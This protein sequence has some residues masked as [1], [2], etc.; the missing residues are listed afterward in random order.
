VVF[1]GD[2]EKE[3]EKGHGGGGPGG[4]KKNKLKDAAKEG[5]DND[6]E[7]AAATETGT[8]SASGDDKDGGRKAAA[9][10][11]VNTAVG[12]VPR[13]VTKAA[14]RREAAERDALRKEFLLLQTA[15]KATEIAIP[16]VFYDGTNIPG[17][18]VRVKKGDHIWV[19]LD[20]SR[21]V[22]AQLGVGADKSANARRDWARVSVDDL[23]LVRGTMIIP[24]VS[25]FMSLLYSSLPI[26]T[27]IFV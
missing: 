8:E 26:Y 27:N 14:L 15:V 1:F 2:E 16:F 17:G 20:K 3:G 19:F 10:V 5:S 9:K 13:A 11:V 6:G 18:V 7:A 24:H 23:M 21:K 4:G 25:L 12:I 22:G